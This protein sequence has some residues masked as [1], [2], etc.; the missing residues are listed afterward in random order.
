MKK[1]LVVIPAYNEEENIGSLLEQLNGHSKREMLDVLVIDDGS[2]D[3]TVQIVRKMGYKVISQIYNMGYGAALQTAYKYALKNGYDY[4]IQLDADG[5]HD[6]KNIDL[7]FDKLNCF[8]EQSDAPD[9]VIGSRFLDGSQSFHV[10]GLKVIAIK[11]FRRIIKKYTKCT[12]TDPTSGLQGLNRRTIEFYAG[13]RNFDLKYP[14]MNMIIQMLLL[15]YK[16]EEFPAIMHERKY[17]TSMHSGLLKVGKYMVLMSLSSYNAYLRYW[18][19]LK[20]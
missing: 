4:L 7:I 17:G 14:D 16:I 1:T 2:S 13:Y 18:K 15:G 12:L 20:R 10:S 6:L 5:Q 3:K 11:F 9:I 19:R 8:G